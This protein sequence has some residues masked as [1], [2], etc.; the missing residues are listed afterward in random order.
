MNPMLHRSIAASRAALAARLAVFAFAALGHYAFLATLSWDQ[1]PGLGLPLVLAA[2]NLLVLAA[3]TFLRPRGG[4]LRLGP[5]VTVVGATAVVAALWTLAQ[6]SASADELVFRALVAGVG[7]GGVCGLIGATV[8]T[9]LILAV[10]RWR[11]HPAPRRALDVWATLAC[12]ASIFAVMRPRGF[13]HSCWDPSGCR[14]HFLHP[15]LGRLLLPLDRSLA[16]LALLIAVAVIVLDLGLRRVIARARDG[17]VEGR[18]VP[19]ASEAE[20]GDAVSLATMHDEAMV[21]VVG[22]PREAGYRDAAP[23]PVLAAFPRETRVSWRLLAMP[24]VALI[25]ALGLAYVD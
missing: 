9:P 18:R 20:A 21:A 19:L 3:V 4:G 24:A 11:A 7:G 25:C 23:E 22:A 14:A 15:V 10:E 8:A 17:A 12:M 16:A 2:P 13:V 6:R 5:T 1:G